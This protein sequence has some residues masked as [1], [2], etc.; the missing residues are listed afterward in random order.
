MKI[1]GFEWD[2]GNVLHIQLGHGIK[3]EEAEEVFAAM[4]LFRKTKKGH[5]AAMGP[6]FEGR[7]L[8]V[9]FELKGNGIARII[10]GWDM[11]YAEKKYWRK[12]RGG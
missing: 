3:P 8:T 12:N 10:T 9:V 4:P 5:Y 1:R 7:F 2:D 11:E 6:T